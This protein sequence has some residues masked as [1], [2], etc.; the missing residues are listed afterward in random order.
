M[1]DNKRDAA[2]FSAVELLKNM[3][4]SCPESFLLID[5][6]Y[7]VLAF[8][9]IAAEKVRQYVNKDIALG[10]P[11]RDYSLPEYWNAFEKRMK[12]VFAGECIEFE[13]EFPYPEGKL[14][15]KQV[16]CFPVPEA[17]GS[18]WAA[19][20]ISRDISKRK[21]IEKELAAHREDLED[22]VRKR[23]DE[24]NVH[25]EELAEKNAILEKKNIALSELLD[26]IGIEKKRIETRIRLNI[27]NVLI[28]LVRRL[29]S[30]DS[31]EISSYLELLEK[32]INDLMEP[33]AEN[34]SDNRFRLSSRKIE[35]C[36]L[37]RNGMITKEI[38]K[39]LNISA[40]TVE[41]HRSNIRVKLGITNRKIT[42]ARFLKN[43]G[44]DS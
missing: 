33:L 34:L 15:W 8:N 12:K 25:R 23:T 42:I 29:E 28:P 26:Q 13:K 16:R 24:L 4:S 20:M 2:D 10:N 3:Y 36:T 18:V 38:A 32:N 31:S 14:T 5:R 7:R 19:A 39:F 21:F 37:I 17:D 44:A 43:G 11:F 35:V 30:V 40:K 41:R 22:Q 6:N 9:K 27:E 1:A